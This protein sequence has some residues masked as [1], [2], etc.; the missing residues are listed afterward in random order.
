MLWRLLNMPRH[1]DT[2]VTVDLP[3]H[4][5]AEL[6]VTYAFTPGR[7]DKLYPWPGEQGYGP[8][9]AILKVEHNGVDVR[10]ALTKKQIERIEEQIIDEEG[11]Q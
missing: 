4:E 1:S 2:T 10:S 3:D 6:A 7:P 11:D 9:V 8:E 5:D